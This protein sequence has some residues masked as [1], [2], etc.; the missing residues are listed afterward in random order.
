M[1][2]D[3]IDRRTIAIKVIA[4]AMITGGVVMITSGDTIITL[5]K[6]WFHVS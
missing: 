6:G 3:R 5:F 4:I 2:N 1:I